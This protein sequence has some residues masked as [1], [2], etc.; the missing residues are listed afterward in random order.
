MSQFLKDL[1][2]AIK[3]IKHQK[4]SEMYIELKPE[5][6]DLF[7]RIFGNINKLEGGALDNA[8]CLTEA[9]L[10]GNQQKTP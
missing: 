2:E 5:Q 9:T 3:H 1:N 7:N 4:L 8:I 10:T 6:K